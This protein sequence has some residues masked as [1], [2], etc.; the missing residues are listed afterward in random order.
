MRRVYESHVKYA[1][2]S[3]QTYMKRELIKTTQKFIAQRRWGKRQ[4]VDGSVHVMM[5]TMMMTVVTL[6][7]VFNTCKRA[8]NNSF[9]DSY[10]LF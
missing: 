8:Y 7:Y 4:K 10:D 6:M 9:R 5:M 2:D 1:E 3:T